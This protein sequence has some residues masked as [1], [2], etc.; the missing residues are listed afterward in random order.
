VAWPATLI[1]AFPPHK[2]EPVQ[3]CPAVMV[4]QSEF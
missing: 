2:Q 3:I 1:A 4:K